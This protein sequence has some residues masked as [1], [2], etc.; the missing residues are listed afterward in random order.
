MVQSNAKLSKAE[1]IA[2]LYKR[3]NL[4]Y[5][6]H[7]AQKL[8]YDKYIEADKNTISVWEISR[9]FGKTTLLVMMSY[10]QC[11]KKP[12][13]LVKYLTDTK[14]HAESIVIPLFDQFFQDCPEELRPKYLA[15]KFKYIFP[16]G[17]QIQ[18]AGSDGGHYE[19]LRGQK[20]DLVL[21]DEA[22]FCSNLSEIIKS[23]LLPTTIHTGGKII[24]A[25][26][27]P[28]DPEHEFIE[29]AE[30]AEL[31]GLYHKFTIEDNPILTREEKDR[32]IKNM[33]G[34]NHPSVRRE[35]FCERIRNVDSCVIPEFTDELVTNIVKT[36][37]RPPFF[38][39]YVSM[40]IGGK[41][42]TAVLYGYYDFRLDKIIIEDEIV[43]DFTKKDQNIEKL[44]KAMV[45]MEASL[46]FNEK[47]NELKVPT[48]RVSDINPIVTQEISKYSNRQIYFSN[49]RKDD[50]MAAV[51]NLRSLLAAEKIII[52]PKCPNLLRHLKNAKWS[53]S[54]TTLDFARSADNGHYDL[55]DALVY[56]TRAVDCKKNPY[57]P[58][59]G[60]NIDRQ[61]IQFNGTNPYKTSNLAATFKK[62]YNK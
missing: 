6:F 48:K 24:L 1:A 15:N 52:S 13:S 19:K 22:G 21:V 60:L 49:A 23:V 28:K 55:V 12:N 47:V 56:F 18:L 5:K 54:K 27:P 9:Q 17:S 31:N 44:T 33:G 26:T 45:A 35:L 11:L 38:D 62:I 14:V 7:A 34:I 57:P 20:T 50:K 32:M 4:E 59:Y 25:T 8:L 37:E 53:G 46:W 16:N 61:N 2:A 42:L 51:N 30:E 39:N 40:D 3:G 43:Y 41:D 29:F 10:M 58:G 36:W